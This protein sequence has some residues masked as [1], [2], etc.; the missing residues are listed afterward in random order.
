MVK[1]INTIFFIIL[2]LFLQIYSFYKIVIWNIENKKSK[3]IIEEIKKDEKLYNNKSANEIDI[4]IKK[5]KKLNTDTVAWLKINNTNIDYPVLK[6]KNNQYY[7]NHDFDKKENNSGWIFA[8]YR[9]KFNGEDR[10]IIIYGHNRRDKSMFGTLK[11]TL[12]DSW[13]DEKENLYITLI[14]K[15]NA[16]KYLVFSVYYEKANEYGIQTSFKNDMKYYEFLKNIKYKSIKNF[17]IELKKSD[18]ILILCTCGNN[19]KYRIM[20]HAVKI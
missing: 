10:N 13:Y 6:S 5:L 14:E 17:N 18:K 20:I 4:N 19:N 1:K 15:D 12:S 7:L 16:D 8:D 2:L 3:T 9:N 11:N